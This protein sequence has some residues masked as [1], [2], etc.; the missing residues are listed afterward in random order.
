MVRNAPLIR[1]AA[2]RTRRPAGSRYLEAVLALAKTLYPGAAIR[3]E[4]N[5]AELVGGAKMPE[6]LASAC[7]AANTSL[8]RM[9]VDIYVP[10]QVAIEV[11]GEQHEEPVRFANSILDVE[12]ELARRKKMD[13]IKQEALRAAGVPTV[14]VWHDECAA[15]D[16]DG[17]AAKIA[18]ASAAAEEVPVQR[19]RPAAAPD[20]RTR[21]EAF[22]AR[23]ERLERQ[24]KA[25]REAYRKLKARRGKQTAPGRTFQ[26]SRSK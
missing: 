13:A 14:V 15:L 22:K 12:A 11:H 2:S 19:V 21:G 18:A 6:W 1:S 26:R 25:R 4:Q 7:A 3:L 5:L 9:R 8:S 20:A 17:L 24:R 10:G 23:A 16:A